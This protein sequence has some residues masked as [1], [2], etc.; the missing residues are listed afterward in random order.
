MLTP[1]DQQG[2]YLQSDTKALSES[3]DVVYTQMCLQPR[4][5]TGFYHTCAIRGQQLLPSGLLDT[6]DASAG[7]L[8]CWGNNDGGQSNPDPLLMTPPLKGG[9]RWI[10]ISGGYR[11]TCGLRT[12]SY[13]SCFGDGGSEIV[14]G[15]GRKKAPMPPDWERFAAACNA[16][17]FSLFKRK[18]LQVQQGRVPVEQRGMRHH[19][20]HGGYERD[21]KRVRDQIP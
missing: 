16:L 7:T 15:D 19:L 2:H 11:H 3:L 9:D 1:L 17:A 21:Q 14:L 10:S 6:N 18:R 20:H 12:G 5:T 13:V 8:A 4:I